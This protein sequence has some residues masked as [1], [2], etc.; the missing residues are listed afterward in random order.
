MERFELM[1]Y[2][3]VGHKRLKSRGSFLSPDLPG[4]ARKPKEFHLRCRRA[5]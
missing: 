3:A 4:T 1:H 2:S 5:K